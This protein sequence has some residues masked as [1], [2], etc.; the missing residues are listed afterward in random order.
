MNAAL[1][2]G[3]ALPRQAFVFVAMTGAAPRPF[4]CGFCQKRFHGILLC[5]T[6][7]SFQMRF[8]TEEG[9]VIILLP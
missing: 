2:F 9:V 3:F 5:V 4:A 7:R 1:L 6:N 8:I